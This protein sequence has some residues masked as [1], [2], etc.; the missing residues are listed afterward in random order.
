[1]IHI[2]LIPDGNRRFAEK[3]GK[4]KFW[5]HAMGIAKMHEF[6]D[7]VLENDEIDMVSTYALSHEN[8]SRPEEEKEKLWDYYKEEFFRLKTDQRIINNKVRIRVV[9]D[10]SLWREDVR[11]AAEELMEATSGFSNKTF[12]ILL[13]YSG[14]GEIEEAMKKGGLSENLMVPRSV[15]LI[16]RTGGEKRLSG[17]LPLQSAYA[18][19]Y[20]SDSFFPAFT[21][22]EFESII[23]W[24]SERKRKFGR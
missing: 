17:M 18:E 15:D 10:S 1:M 13:V 7:W 20:F 3:A 4:L 11:K 14:R 5:G 6:I 19:I 24:F 23:K 9:G 22:E 21:R 12:N 2:A 16:I 8:L